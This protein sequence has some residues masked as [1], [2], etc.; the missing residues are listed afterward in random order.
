MLAIEVETP[1]SVCHLHLLQNFGTFLQ[2]LKKKKS[3]YY[4]SLIIYV[5]LK[6]SLYLYPPDESEQ[7]LD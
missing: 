5:E 1:V 7:D 4:K 6:E 2:N 3:V